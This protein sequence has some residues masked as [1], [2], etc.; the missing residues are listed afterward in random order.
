M[1][2]LMVITN[3]QRPLAWFTASS[4]AL[5]FLGCY[6]NIGDTHPYLVLA[7]SLHPALVRV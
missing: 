3:D 4:F 2:D 7:D 6:L 5:L 1:H